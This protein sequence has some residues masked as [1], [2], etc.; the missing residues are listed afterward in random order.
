MRL[1][2]LSALHPTPIHYS[3][4]LEMRILEIQYLRICDE[5]FTS[6]PDSIL[7][8]SISMLPLASLWRIFINMAM[9]SMKVMLYFH[10]D[11]HY[12]VERNDDE[13]EGDVVRDDDD[14]EGDVD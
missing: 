9:T 1:K 5:W 7:E 8:T 11:R 14:H 12:H 2:Y 13:H 4:I 6:E 10:H 3:R